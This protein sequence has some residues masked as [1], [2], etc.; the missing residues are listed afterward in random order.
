MADTLTGTH[1]SFL[2]NW[3][4]SAHVCIYCNLITLV[5]KCQSIFKQRRQKKKLIKKRLHFFLM[6]V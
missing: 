4:G 6:K 1:G 5:K 3:V 2:C